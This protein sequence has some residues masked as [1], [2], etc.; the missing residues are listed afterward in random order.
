MHDES[1]SSGNRLPEAGYA[2]RARRNIQSVSESSVESST[3]SSY[4][5]SIQ[6]WEIGTLVLALQ[7]ARG[8]LNHSATV[9]QVNP[10]QDFWGTIRQNF[11][12]KVK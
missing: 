6:L 1:F 7:P 5:Y 3:R 4:T 2:V 10:K 9:S 8:R 12:P 11:T